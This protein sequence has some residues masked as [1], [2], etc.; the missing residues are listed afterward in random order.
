[1]APA[2]ANAHRPSTSHRGRGARSECRSSLLAI[3]RFA[4]W[5]GAVS[6]LL[7]LLIIPWAHRAFSWWQVFR[8][9]VSVGAAISLW[10]C[11]HKFERRSVGSYGLSASWV[12][13]RSLLAGLLFGAGALGV[14]FSIHLLSGACQIQVT[15]DRWRLWWT[16]VGFIPAA[17]LISVLE[18][19]VF[20]GVIL[21]HLLTISQSVA[22][23]ASS[24]VY[25]LVHLK[26]PEWTLGTGFE[27]IGLVL[28]GGVLSLSYL[29]TQQLYLSIGLHAA[30]AYGARINKLLIGF[31]DARHAWL[32]G[33]S[34]LVNGCLGWVILLAL[35]G[36][37]VWWA[38]A[39]PR[40]L[41][42]M[43]SRSAGGPS[44]REA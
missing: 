43:P 1:M 39:N 42:P 13:T 14:L 30:L 25:A 20:R 23:A 3:L 28:L 18:E 15:P 33:T 10:V 2:A 37:I 26:S 24:A 31:P 35:G 36:V 41:S 38:K 7:S 17:I 22:V 4:L 27:L 11:I 44:S 34:R 29:M 32:L 8:R 19:L 12:G 21:Q 6:L 9:C 40:Q 16:L 5:T